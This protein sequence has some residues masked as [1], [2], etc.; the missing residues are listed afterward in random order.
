MDGRIKSGHDINASELPRKKCLVVAS[1][2]KQDSRGSS[3]A[4]MVRGQRHPSSEPSRQADSELGPEAGASPA[5]RVLTRVIPLA[6]P[7]G[8]GMGVR[9]VS[10]RIEASA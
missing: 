8:R 3:P 7:A 4:M 6:P 2:S 1:Q 5:G 10:A 9:G